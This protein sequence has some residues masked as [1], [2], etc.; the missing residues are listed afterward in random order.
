MKI[1]INDLEEKDI[2]KIDSFKKILKYATS[3]GTG[4]IF[5]GIVSITTIGVFWPA[6]LCAYLSSYIFSEILTD[7]TDKYIDDHIMVKNE[8]EEEG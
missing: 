6:K 7:K 8:A 1:I 2:P 5:G 3:M 4:V